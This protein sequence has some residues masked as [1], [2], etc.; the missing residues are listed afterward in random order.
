MDELGGQF[1]L[2]ISSP[3]VSHAMK[4]YKFM[5][6]D[7]FFQN[8]P[9]QTDQDHF[10]KQSCPEDII[11]IKP[12]HKEYA[13]LNFSKCMEHY[14]ESAYVSSW[15][16]NAFLTKNAPVQTHSS[17]VL[18]LATILCTGGYDGPRQYAGVSSTQNDRQLLYSSTTPL[19]T[20][21][22]VRLGM[23]TL[24]QCRLT[25]IGLWKRDEKKGMLY[26]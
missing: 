11:K 7:L 23:L 16:G 5:P 10:K 19:D 3:F 20:N 24:R 17:Q 12:M 8:W 15:W 26:S 25:C 22:S 21:H 1:R 4:M 14:I 2:Y 18:V 9:N 6:I 13:Y